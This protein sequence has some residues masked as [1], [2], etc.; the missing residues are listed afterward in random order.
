[1][2]IFSCEK[3]PVIT[4]DD[5]GGGQD[6][7]MVEMTP[8]EIVKPRSFPDPVIPEDNQLTVERIELGKKLFFDNRLSNDG[9]ACADCHEP[10]HGFS[11]EGV[12]DFDKGLTSLPLINLAWIDTFMWSG[13]IV[14][15]LEDVMGF[16][17]RDRFNTDIS[18]ING[19]SEYQVMFKDFYGT[20]EIERIHIQKALAQYM[21]VLVSRDTK[22]DRWLA[23]AI[24]LNP[25]E[26]RGRDIFFTE[27]G[28]C[29]HCHTAVVFTD[30][31]LHNNGLDSTYKTNIDLGHFNVTGNPAHKGVFRS[32]NLRNVALRSHY[33]HDGRFTS[34]EDVVEFYNTGVK[35]VSNVDPLMTKANRQS[36]LGLGLDEVQKRDLI[37][38][39]HT[40]TDSTMISDPLFEPPQ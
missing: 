2:L 29:F 15:T 27:K 25:S 37:A 28:D 32:P 33:M 12:S 22:Y 24:R 21:R 16:E 30:G 38:F 40:L 20:N 7:T 8:Y 4:N 13:R 31:G 11:V 9:Q 17:L 19:I 39:L 26:E 18:K 35:Q 14:G 6:T 1:M 34:L 3:D 10:E 23:G 5:D 36:G